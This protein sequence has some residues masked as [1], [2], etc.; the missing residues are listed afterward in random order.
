MRMRPF[1]LVLLGTISASICQDLAASVNSEFKLCPFSKSACAPFSTN[2]A[3]KPH[4]SGSGATALAVTRIRDRVKAWRN[5][6]DPITMNDG[7]Q[8][9]L[10]DHV[11]QESGLFTAAFDQMD[12]TTWNLRRRARNHEPR[13][14]AP[15]PDIDPDWRVRKRRHQR[16]QLQ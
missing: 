5:G 9:N 4:N 7:R 12:A 3:I 1:S 2:G 16:Q 6:L 11:A 8:S 13:K 10:P 15:G 14:P